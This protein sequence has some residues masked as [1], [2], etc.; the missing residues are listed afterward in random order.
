MSASSIQNSYFRLCLL[1]RN[2]CKFALK[3]DSHRLRDDATAS[4]FPT[5][6]LVSD[7]CGCAALNFMC[8]RLTYNVEI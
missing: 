2:Q 7:R 1:K 6:V 8:Y 4:E 5:E 3:F